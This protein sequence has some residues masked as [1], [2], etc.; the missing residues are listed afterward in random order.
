[1]NYY[2]ERIGAT[3][4]VQKVSR[5]SP[6]PQI[7]TPH[8]RRRVSMSTYNW[9]DTV[10]NDDKLKVLINPESDYTINAANAF[11]RLKDDIIV[12][13]AF[14]TAQAGSDGQ[15][16]VPFPVAQILGDAP[17]N[18]DSSLQT[19]TTDTGHWSIQRLR[20]IKLMFDLA[21]VDPDEERYAVISPYGLTQMLSQPQ[22]TSADYNSV[23]ALVEGAVDSMMGFKF[24]MSNRLPLVGGV[25]FGISYP[26]NAPVGVNT[27]DRLSLFF[28]MSGVG[29]AVQEEVITKMAERA[30]LSFTT[31]IYME[32][33]MGATRIEEV[34]VVQAATVEP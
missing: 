32:M 7:S 8:S 33:V 31:Q 26:A 30:D 5:A 17:I 21:D 4:A 18:N 2:F 3:A 24:I 16:S 19:G 28:C 20:R 1:M 22:I 15:T 11:G 27:G 25:T 14:G 12:A 34:K 13:G 6:T 10:D 9:G 23:K 29:L